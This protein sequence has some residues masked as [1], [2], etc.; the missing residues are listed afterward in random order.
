VL[1][2]AGQLEPLAPAPHL[3]ANE[4]TSGREVKSENQDRAGTVLETHVAPA[5]ATTLLPAAS[6]A[7][8]RRALA[9]AGQDH[10]LFELGQA[11]EFARAGTGAG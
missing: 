3:I 11:I 8:L 2:E 9:G 10:G 5:E 4:Q 7:D 6:F 1:H